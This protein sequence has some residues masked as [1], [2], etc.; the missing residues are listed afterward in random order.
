M[1]LEQAV[2][3][4]AASQVATMLEPLVTSFL[5]SLS[6]EAR[7]EASQEIEHIRERLAFLKLLPD[8][9]KTR[10]GKYVA[11]HDG[12]VVDAD[13]SLRTLVRRFSERFGDAPVYIGFVGAPA[14]VARVPTPFFHRPGQ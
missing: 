8:L 6:P 7:Q 9:A 11:V 3:S 13:A 4:V 2:F 10:F 1:N 12:Q 14:P 5:A